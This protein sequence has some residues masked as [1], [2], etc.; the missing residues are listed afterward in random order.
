MINTETTMIHKVVDL[1]KELEKYNESIVSLWDGASEQEIVDTETHI[2]QVLPDEYKEF[3]RI[4]NGLEFT[5]EYILRVGNSVRTSAFSMNEVYDFEHFEAY[6]PMPSYI[7]PFSPDGYGNHYCFDMSRN[8]VVI[9]WQHDL[10]Y[11]CIDPEIVYASM[12]DM[13]KEVFIEWAETNYDGSPK[14]TNNP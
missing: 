9:F 7:I 2:G 5:C 8:G 3:I 11:D 10:D 6:N 14:E 4:S 1:I 12:V 13:I